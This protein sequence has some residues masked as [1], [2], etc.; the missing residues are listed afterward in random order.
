MNTADTESDVGLIYPQEIIERARETVPMTPFALTGPQAESAG[1]VRGYGGLGV[2]R[3]PGE[4]ATQRHPFETYVI[5]W[6]DANHT[7]ASVQV[8]TGTVLNDEEDITDTVTITGINATYALV[9]GDWLYLDTDFDSNGDI[10]ACSLSQATSSGWTGYPSLSPSA[11]KWIQP[12]CHV[13]TF[14]SSKAGGGVPDSGEW[15][16]IES[17][18]FI[19]Q[20]TTTHLVKMQAC[21]GGELRWK[22]VPGAGG[23]G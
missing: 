20:K 6:T 11:T 5:G 1:Q 10:T 7:T 21:I 14:K 22:L 16:Q 3:A 9:S 23:V 19:S 8:Y 2:P 15:S 13:R 12:I 17:D 18:L 4:R